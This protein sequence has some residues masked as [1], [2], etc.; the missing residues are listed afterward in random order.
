MFSS[1]SQHN[2]RYLSGIRAAAVSPGDPSQEHICLV[3]LSAHRIFLQTLS[4]SLHT[5][6]DQGL[7]SAGSTG[8][9]RLV[10]A[11]TQPA[12]RALAPPAGRGPSREHLESSLTCTL[13]TM[14]TEDPAHE[15]PR[16]VAQSSPSEPPRLPVYNPDTRHAAVIT[17]SGWGARA[18]DVSGYGF[19]I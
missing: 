5:R 2:K 12:T 18:E 13:G 16:H 1:R 9:K 8:S 10:Q 19:L 17:G 6:R 4:H 15:A 7:A 14:S 11:D 3:C